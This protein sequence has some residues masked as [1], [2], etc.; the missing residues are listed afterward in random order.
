MLEL[1]GI[2][3]ASRFTGRI[4]EAVAGFATTALAVRLLG[5]SRYGTLALAL[6]I[7][8]LVGVVGRLG[9]GVA[10]TRRIAAMRATGDQNGIEQTAQAVTTLM[11]SLAALGSVLVAGLI[12][13]THRDQGAAASLLV[14]TGL[15]LFLL[16]VN[17]SVAGASIAQGMG[18]M[19]LMEA[20]RLA[21][22]FLQLLAA[23]VLT[24]L[25][26]AD[27]VALAL[28]FGAAGLVTCVVT[29]QLIRGILFGAKHLFRP[30]ARHAIELVIL[31][32]PYAV[33]AVGT[34]VISRFDVLVLGF[35]DT[36]A[37]V[38]GYESTLRLVDAFLLLIPG[39][40]IAPFVPAATV[41]FTRG[42]STPFGDLYIFVSKLAFIGTMPAILALVAFPEATLRALFGAD[43]QVAEPIVW[44]LLAGYAVNLAFGLNSQALIAAGQR[45]RLARTYLISLTLMVGLAFALIPGL[46][47]TGAALSTAC[48]YVV[49]NVGV[50]LALFRSTGVSPFRRDM[51]VL[52]LTSV[53]PVISV[54]VVR[55]AVVNPG[56]LW[57]L[58]S[59]LGCWV[60][61]VGIGVWTRAIVLSQLLQLIPRTRRSQEREIAE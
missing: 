38:G 19:V 32:A 21:L 46:G 1:V 58:V 2:G 27:T 36:S 20:P 18:R 33:A 59:S 43:Y 22:V 34:Q 31:A 23:V 12:Y 56:V 24:V 61:W 14:G 6:A 15:G 26:V 28:G 53:L 8:A 35:T 50:G 10:T 57:V 37:A 45:R 16:G 25:G 39:V 5:T 7:V 30:A 48:S 17:T 51:V 3:I 4:L 40:L 49:L 11:I 42:D 9:L 44:I 13:L 29:R 54:L 47:A 60:L 41:L 55:R 52:L